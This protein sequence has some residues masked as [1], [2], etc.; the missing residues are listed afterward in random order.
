VSGHIKNLEV[1]VGA[2]LLDRLP[3]RL[4]L[5]RA[6][7]LLY[8]HARAIVDE[9]E[10]AIRE[11]K[12][13]LNHLEGA[14]VL[15]ASTIPGEYLLPPALARFRGQF[16]RVKV[17]IRIS[18]SKAVCHEVLAGRAELGFVG[19][20]FEAAGI[21]FR[22]LASDELA[23]VVPNTQKWRNVDFVTRAGLRKLPFL[24]RESGSGTR[25]AFEKI[26]RQSVESLNVVGSFGSTSAIKEALKADLGVSVLSLRAVATEIAAGLLKPV[27]IRGFKSMRRDFYVVVNRR[28]SL[29]PIAAA[30]LECMIPQDDKAAMS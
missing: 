6:G 14:L 1:F 13:F 19:A 3:R 12:R 17:E 8:A 5:T 18:D 29:S 2:P 21:E 24:V 11:L 9:K 7:E 10:A 16:P 26:L 20:R 4:A 30:F 25:S 22:H 28:L 23:L 27:Q 15:C